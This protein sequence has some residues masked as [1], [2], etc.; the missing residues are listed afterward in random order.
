MS[1]VLSFFSHII[2]GNAFPSADQDN[3]TRLSFDLSEVS[4]NGSELLMSELHLFKRRM[5]EKHIG[6]HLCEITIYGASFENG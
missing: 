2:L 3:E 4:L 6:S 5:P 1:F